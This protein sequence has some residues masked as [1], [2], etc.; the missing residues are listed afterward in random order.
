VN[1]LKT[2]R[3]ALAL[4]SFLVLAAAAPAGA[5]TQAVKHHHKAAAPHVAKSHAAAGAVKTRSRHHAAVKGH[6]R[7]HTKT[8]VAEA[9]PPHR[10]AQLCRTVMVRHHE[11]EKCR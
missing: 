8:A 1:G 6:A 2:S 11:V 10:H 5:V 7:H 4:A 3:V 9:G